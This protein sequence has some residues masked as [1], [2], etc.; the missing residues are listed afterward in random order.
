MGKVFSISNLYE[1]YLDETSILCVTTV[2][3]LIEKEVIEV[4]N[5]CLKSNKF[6]I[7]RQECGEEYVIISASV[8]KQYRR[9][10]ENMLQA[11][12][13]SNISNNGEDYPGCLCTRFSS[14]FDKQN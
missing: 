2:H 14:A 4:L 8:K 10:L 7:Y 6:P 1:K 13:R 5:S 3:K 11:F 12:Q 9:L